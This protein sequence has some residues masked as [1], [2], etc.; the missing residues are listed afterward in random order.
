M[1]KPSANSATSETDLTSTPVA[2][3][4]PDGSLLQ[5]IQRM[6]AE[7][8]SFKAADV[9]AVQEKNIQQDFTLNASFVLYKNIKVTPVNGYFKAKSQDH[10]APTDD[11]AQSGIVSLIEKLEIDAQ[12][13]LDDKVKNNPTLPL[14]LEEG[15]YLGTAT[16]FWSLQK[17]E[18]CNEE[19][20]I[21]C[22]MCMGNREYV[23]PQ[24]HGNQRLPCRA[25]GCDQGRTICMTCLGN[26]EVVQEKDVPYEFSGG[27]KEGGPQT[28][29]YQ[30]VKE[31]IP[32]PNA[33]CVK[34]TVPC[35]AC[36]G[37]AVVPCSRCTGKGACPCEKCSKSGKLKCPECAG[38]HETGQMYE[39]SIDLKIH[40][41]TSLPGSS[42]EYAKKIFDLE[43]DP[44]RL[45][46]ISTSVIQQ[47]YV[48]WRGL[49]NHQ[50]L[51]IV[52]TGHLDIESIE[53]ACN[54]KKYKAIAYG[55]E[56]QWL[57]QG[58]IIENLV[59]SDFE[60]LRKVGKQIDTYQLPMTDY[61]TPQ[62]VL[63]RFV[64]VPDNVNALQKVDSSIY[65]TEQGEESRSLVLKC[66]QEMKFNYARIQVGM[67]CLM[68]FLTM[69]GLWLVI[70]STGFWEF[71]II[72]V[73]GY[74]LSLV[75]IVKMDTDVDKL[76]ARS[77]PSIKNFNVLDAA[78]KPLLR[79]GGWEV[80][81]HTG[82]R[83]IPSRIVWMFYWLLMACL[84]YW[85]W[86]RRLLGW[87]FGAT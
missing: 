42:S 49:D 56:R 66:A 84:F 76:Y 26:G 15:I 40:H 3:T 63:Q 35:L 28:V 1:N 18:T 48:G 16:R 43:Q 62:K 30:T 13:R 59:Q 12:K 54:S 58:S 69:M 14:D 73:A 6:V 31:M 37:N 57:T 21:V 68:I 10:R 72:G 7:K 86:I 4:V 27:G 83:L 79:H 47:E 20:E 38:S 5:E 45:A 32:C 78:G 85:F 9:V 29:K 82:A 17:C 81:S 87:L 80:F 75:L 65:P 61:K 41:T 23:C 50:M 77:M 64:S 71:L 8:T 34:G 44:V 74:C 46:S 22:D 60:E 51:K 36:R 11:L 53:V 19:G 2:G 55:K 24:C 33:E 25:P 52:Y 70:G 67:V 39:C